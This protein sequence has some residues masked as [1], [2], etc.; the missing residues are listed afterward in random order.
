MLTRLDAF[1][2]QTPVA[3][4]GQQSFFNVHN[5]P[6]QLG[7]VEASGTNLALSSSIVRTIDLEPGGKN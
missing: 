2:G 1:I 7:S 4:G 6:G 5:L 3:D